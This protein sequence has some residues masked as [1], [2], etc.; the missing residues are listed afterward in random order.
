MLLQGY[1]VVALIFYYGGQYTTLI[2]FTLAFTGYCF[3]LVSGNRPA[4]PI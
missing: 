3:A 2:V 1:L 4:Q